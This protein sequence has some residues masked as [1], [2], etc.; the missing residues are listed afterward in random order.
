[1]DD[2]GLIPGVTV[3][4]DQSIDR[5]VWGLD[6]RTRMLEARSLEDRQSSE[7]RYLQMTAHFETRLANLDVTMRLLGTKL[8]TVSQKQDVAAGMRDEQNVYIR[9][10]LVVFS[11]IIGGA[12]FVLEI[13]RIKFHF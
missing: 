1:M 8:D 11:L 7:A 12:T 5:V 4:V 13:V 2:K 6:E 3:V 9:N 10:M